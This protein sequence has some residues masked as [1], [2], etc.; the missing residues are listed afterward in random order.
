MA[1]AAATID[2]LGILGSSPI[3]RPLR[4]PEW[5]IGTG[6]PE[7]RNFSSEADYAAVRRDS[8][9]RLARLAILVTV[10]A[11]RIALLGHVVVLGLLL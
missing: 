8:V 11:V 1:V 5:K 7:M 6:K 2:A 4:C 10:E 3:G 9:E